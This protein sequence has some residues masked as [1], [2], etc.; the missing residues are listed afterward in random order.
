MSAHFPSPWPPRLLFLL[1]TSAALGLIVLVF[2]APL[3]D[4]RGTSATG[5]PRV[6]AVFARDATLRRTA[7][8]SGIGL[9]VTACVFFRLPPGPRRSRNR[10]L[11]PPPDIA[12]A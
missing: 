9:L 12:G 6:V 1:G 7:I 11:P 4:N 8:A 3:L 2:L 5:W 10:S